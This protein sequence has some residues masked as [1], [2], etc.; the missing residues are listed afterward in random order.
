MERLDDFFVRL[1]HGRTTL[2]RWYTYAAWM[3]GYLWKVV[4]GSAQEAEISAAEKS[5]KASAKKRQFPRWFLRDFLDVKYS[6]SHASHDSHEMLTNSKAEVMPEVVGASAEVVGGPS[7]SSQDSNRDKVSALDLEI[8]RRKVKLTLLAGNLVSVLAVCEG[9]SCIMS[10]VMWLFVKANLSDLSELD[11]KEDYKQLP[12]MPSLTVVA[13]GLIM[14]VFEVFLSDY[15][16]ATYSHHYL[17]NEMS[18][19]RDS[20]HSEKDSCG[21]CEDSSVSEEDWQHI[22]DGVED[23]EHPKEPRD[24][25]H[26]PQDGSCRSTCGWCWNWGKSKKGKMKKEWGKTK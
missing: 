2:E 14:F 6:D 1:V 5:E 15:L 16:V 25:P 8:H 13:N 24:E 19:T 10:T 17:V 21:N 9:A 20:A 7:V 22:L 26:E 4:A 3:G 12:P 23:L 11:Y 18:A